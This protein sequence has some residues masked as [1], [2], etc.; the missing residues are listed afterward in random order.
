MPDIR[1]TNSTGQAMKRMAIGIAALAVLTG[2]LFLA[3]PDSFYL[4]AKAIHVLAVISW[5][6]GML[7]L[8]RLFVYHVDAEKGSV[9]SETFK[10]MERRLLRGIINPAMTLTWVFGLWLAWKGFAFQG[11]WLHAKIAAVLLMSGVHGYLAGAV[12]KFA[13][14]RNEKPA[15]YWRIVNEIP[16]LLMI[17]IVI[18]VV[19]KP[20]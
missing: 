8:P 1:N 3:A 2:L 5:M 14:D 7:Y 13:D 20:F 9:Q 16:T 11:G 17:V 10:V 18:L 15:R 12:R 4:W 6:A 19:V